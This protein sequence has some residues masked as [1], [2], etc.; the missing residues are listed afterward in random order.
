MQGRR[1]VV[2]DVFT[3]EALTGN[4]LAVVLDGEGLDTAAMQRIAREFNLSE[5]PSSCRL[6]MPGTRR[7]YA[8]SRRTT[9]CLSP[10]IRRWAPLS[11][12]PISPATRR[13]RSS[14]W[15]RISGRCGAPSAIRRHRLCGVQL[16]EAA[17]SHCLF[18][19]SPMSSARR[20]ASVRRTWLRK[21]SCLLLVRG[22]TLRDDS[23]FGAERRREG[24][25]RQ[26]RLDGILAARQKRQRGERLCLLPR[27]RFTTTAPFIRACSCPANRSYEDP[28]TGSAAAAFA[29]A[30]AHFDQ[31]VDGPTRLWIEQ[32]IEMGRPS[33]I[34][35]EIDMTHGRIE[36]A[37][38]GGQAV[39]VAEG[40]LFV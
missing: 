20:W 8:S 25:V 21:P 7:G 9:R 34:R 1:Y 33:R 22:R 27:E 30:V 26:C 3:G 29:G 32:G 38:I 5:S 37:R 18:G 36:A 12:W 2:Y 28:A 11:R 40:M 17:G 35:L 6:R 16:G 23:C 24:A 15:R 13:R 14:C 10:A 39:K 31:P 4:P 19:R